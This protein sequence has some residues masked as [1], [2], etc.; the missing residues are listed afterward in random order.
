MW[1]EKVK[2]QR[3]KD[4]RYKKRKV[5]LLNPAALEFRFSCFFDCYEGNIDAIKKLQ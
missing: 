3:N 4:K 1:M 5:R 2:K